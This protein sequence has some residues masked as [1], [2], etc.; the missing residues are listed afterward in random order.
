[1]QGNVRVELYR[2]LLYE[3]Y[4]PQ[5]VLLRGWLPRPAMDPLAARVLANERE[6]VESRMVRMRKRRKP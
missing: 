4:T 3:R 1:M 2:A 6:R 5:S